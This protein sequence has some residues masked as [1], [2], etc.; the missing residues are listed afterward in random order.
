ME[1]ENRGK[2]MQADDGNYK[3]SNINEDC[4]EYKTE[5][6]KKYKRIMLCWE[7]K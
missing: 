1:L 4:G 2:T 5:L 3:H 7:D 6:H